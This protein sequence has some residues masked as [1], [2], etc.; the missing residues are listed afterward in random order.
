MKRFSLVLYLKG[1]AM[2]AADMVP[3]VSGGTMALVL[4]IYWELIFAIKSV[5]RTALRIYSQEGFAVAW[6]QIN[7]DFMITLLAGMLTSI[8]FLAKAINYLLTFYEMFLWSFFFG[9]VVGSFFILIKKNRPARW[10]Q[11]LL[12]CCGV[13]AALALSR[14][15]L[16]AIELGYLG[17]FFSGW[18]AFC[19]M[20]IPGISGTLILVLLG[21]YSTIIQALNQLH[22][23]VLATFG[24]GGL[25][26]LM[27]FSRLL[28]RLRPY[29]ATVLVTMCGFLLGSLDAI[30]PWKQPIVAELG[31]GR[32]RN[33]VNLWP[34]QYA[35]VFDSDPQVLFCVLW[36][37]VGFFFVALINYAGSNSNKKKA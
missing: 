2:G 12:F 23:D 29:E 14:A 1:M 4:G 34:D 3:G 28:A 18:L 15:P 33:S 37:S 10:Y 35:L 32:V 22:L 21:L 24:I 13:F 36:A 19:A 17:L 11:W 25:I 7:G 27:A 30:W 9:L 26:G 6:R 16:M 8:L 20:I 31:G 5:G